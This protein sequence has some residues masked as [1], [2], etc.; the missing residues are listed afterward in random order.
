MTEQM[1]PRRRRALRIAPVLLVAILAA[2]SASSSVT[3]AD[4]PQAVADTAEPATTQDPTSP[5]SDESDSADSQAPNDEADPA[6]M[7][8]T[9]DPAVDDVAD[10]NGEDANDEQATSEEAGGETPVIDGPLVFAA[11]DVP[12]IGITSGTGGQGSRPVLAWV[13]VD[14]AAHYEVSLFAPSGEMYWA[15]S[16]ATPAI[17][18]GG[19][20]LLGPNSAGP[21]VIE[22]MSWYVLAIDAE[23]LIIGQSPLVTTHP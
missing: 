7:A 3:T 21:A 22:G 12:I 15:W 10:A 8:T 14:D 17:P 2:C 13:P 5:A 20:P 18:V 23:G 1:I 6:A 16:G 4:A 9:D 11:L 19:E